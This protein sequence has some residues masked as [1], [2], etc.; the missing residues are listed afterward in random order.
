M[1]LVDSFII[2][3]Y[4]G[5]IWR[6]VLVKGFYNLMFNVFRKGNCRFIF[7][8]ICFIIVWYLLYDLVFEYLFVLVLEKIMYIIVF[9]CIYWRVLNWKIFKIFF[10]K[11]INEIYMNE[12]IVYWKVINIKEF[13]NNVNNLLVFVL[14]LYGR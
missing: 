5:W 4:G 11:I 1:I 6:L 2:K 9:I 3:D 7:S 14:L 12:L 8:V 13:Y 10:F